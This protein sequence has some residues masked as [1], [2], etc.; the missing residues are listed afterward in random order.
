MAK[1]LKQSQYENINEY[2]RAYEEN[3]FIPSKYLAPD[4]KNR[5]TKSLIE[6]DAFKVGLF[7][8]L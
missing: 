3:L 2:H 5:P 4:L 1:E 8:N 6:G 7:E